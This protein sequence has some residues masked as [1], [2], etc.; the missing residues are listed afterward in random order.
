MTSPLI[1]KI[2][3]QMEAERDVFIHK[4]ILDS[5]R[6]CPDCE[7][8]AGRAGIK[9]GYMARS[10]D[11]ALSRLLPLIEK[12]ESQRNEIAFNH[13]KDGYFSLRAE[14][15]EELLKMLEGEK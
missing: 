8:V 5:S 15:N 9:N 3:E 14:L 11:K 12:L 6:C 4:Q 7:S 10:Y 13:V 1:T 2:R